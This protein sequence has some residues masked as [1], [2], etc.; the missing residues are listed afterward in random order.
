MYLTPSD[1]GDPGEGPEHL[2]PGASELGRQLTGGKRGLGSRPLSLP[3]RTEGCS[4]SHL[5]SLPSRV[6]EYL[7]E[8]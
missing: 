6:R 2:S 3:A 8:S 5:T 1:V 7:L 4:V